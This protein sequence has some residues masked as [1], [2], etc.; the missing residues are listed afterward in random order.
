MPFLPRAINCGGVT[1]R[2]EQDW[3]LLE[4]VSCA[5]AA[6]RETLVEEQGGSVSPSGRLLPAGPV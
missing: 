4:A 5:K 1:D 3:E 2:K 6:V